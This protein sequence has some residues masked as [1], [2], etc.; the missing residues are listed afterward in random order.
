MK[1]TTFD[2]DADF[3]MDDFSDIE[4]DM[5]MEFETRYIKPPKTKQIE[6]HLL[7]Y[8]NAQKLANEIQITSDSRHFIVVNGTFYFGDFIEALIVK[9][10]WH[11]SEL[12]VSTLSLCQ[13][14]VDSFKNLLEGGFVDKL[15]LIV[16]D[17]FF[18]HEKHALVPYLYE[19]LD[20]DDKFQL[21]AAGTHCKICLIKTHCGK[22]IVMHGSA[23]L[24]SSSN[25]EQ[26]VIEE[27]KSLYDF[28]QEYQ[29]RILDKYATIDKSIRGKELWKTITN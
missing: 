4:I 1:T 5:E 19:K 17:Y 9:N 28:N 26:V 3:N 24:R 18:S 13:N 11:V 21:A 15:D 20:K 23:N 2:F 29:L 7:K 6:E 8:D 22:S 27:N 25:I 14:N 12:I 16:S 10:N